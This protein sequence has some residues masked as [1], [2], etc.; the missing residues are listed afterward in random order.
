[1]ATE[2]NPASILHVYWKR[3]YARLFA[4]ATYGVSLEAQREGGY[5][6]VLATKNDK[7]VGIEIET[8][9][10]DAVSNVL[11]GLR[12]GFEH[13]VVAATDRN[14]MGIVERQLARAGLIIPSRIELIECGRTPCVTERSLHI[15]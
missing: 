14:A 15:R 8:G 11:N 7:R 6:D 2:D 9:K 4:D 10:S 5:V 3:Y 1:M 13:V 12:S